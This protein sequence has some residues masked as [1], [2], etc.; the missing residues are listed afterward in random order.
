[1]LLVALA[2]GVYAV[3]AVDANADDA[4]ADAAATAS[5]LLLLLGAETAVSS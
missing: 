4:N 2:P 3:A 1:M 5:A